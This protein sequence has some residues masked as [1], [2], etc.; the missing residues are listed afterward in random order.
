MFNE[1]VGQG[2][3][4]L[5]GRKHRH[6]ER[7]IASAQLFDHVGSYFEPQCHCHKGVLH[8]CL[9]IPGVAVGFVPG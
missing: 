5:I 8:S 9:E 6:E 1:C 2:S 4:L 3:M 7:T